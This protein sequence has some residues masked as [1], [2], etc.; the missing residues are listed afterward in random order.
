MFRFGV[1]HASADPKLGTNQLLL[2]FKNSLL[3]LSLLH[4]NGSVPGPHRPDPP[5]HTY[6]RGISQFSFVVP[7]MEK[8]IDYLTLARV[9]IIFAFTNTYLKLKLAFVRDGDDNIVQFIQPI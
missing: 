6:Y 2:G 7:D 3:R 8:T 5:N 1:V 4:K 9:K